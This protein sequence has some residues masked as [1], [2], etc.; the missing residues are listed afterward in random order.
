M[1]PEDK[2]AIFTKIGTGKKFASVDLPRQKRAGKG[3]QCV[4]G[5]ELAAAALVAD[6]DSLLICGDK[7]SLC[8][9]AAD[10]PNVSRGPSI[11]NQVI[12]GPVSRVCKI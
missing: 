9:S 8:I 11:G 10:I 12:K 5:E 6:E 3:L 2:L 1:I 7:T 4:K